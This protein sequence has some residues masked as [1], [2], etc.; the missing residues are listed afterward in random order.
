MLV[1]WLRLHTLGLARPSVWHKYATPGYRC[2]FIVYPGTKFGIGPPIDAGFYYDVDTG[3][4]SLSVTDLEAIE[5]KIEA[6]EVQDAQNAKKEKEEKAYEQ[7]EM[8]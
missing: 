5:K 4:I 2:T 6:K 7:Q 1:R 3:D 8:R